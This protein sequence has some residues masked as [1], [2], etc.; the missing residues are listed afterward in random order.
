MSSPPNHTSGAGIFSRVR[1]NAQ[2]SSAALRRR[3]GPPLL[4]PTLSA[5]P[6]FA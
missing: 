5:K 2:P 3:G 6:R 4:V 1:A